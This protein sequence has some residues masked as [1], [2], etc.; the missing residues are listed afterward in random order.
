MYPY[1]LLSTHCTVQLDQYDKSPSGHVFVKATNKK[2][3][4]PQVRTTTRV[5]IN[6]SMTCVLIT[7][8]D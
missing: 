4:L 8:C 1:V 3:I 5:Y 6:A 2:G 7:I